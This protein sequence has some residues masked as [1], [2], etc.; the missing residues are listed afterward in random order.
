MKINYRVVGNTNIG[1]WSTT[2]KEN[3]QEYNCDMCNEKLWV[4]PDGSLYCNKEHT[5]EERSCT[6]CGKTSGL[7]E[8]FDMCITCADERGL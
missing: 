1:K 2:K 3:K 5:E 7:I 6:K 8:E 4:K